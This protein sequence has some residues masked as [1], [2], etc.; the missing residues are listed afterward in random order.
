[1]R[2]LMFGEILQ[3]EATLSRTYPSVESVIRISRILI[4][5]FLLS[6]LLQESIIAASFSILSVPTA[7][8]EKA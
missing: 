5:L 4:G 7:H 8:P 6:S 3:R 2:P 1:M